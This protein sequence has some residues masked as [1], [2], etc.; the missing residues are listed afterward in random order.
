MT[1]RDRFCRLMTYQSVDRVPAMQV[2]PFEQPAIEQWRKEGLPADQSPQTFLGIESVNF[3]PGAGVCPDP[4]FE[5]KILAEDSES[6]TETTY[7]GAVVRRLNVSPTTF[8]GHVD[9][10]IKTRDDWRAYRERLRPNT[11]RRMRTDL[12]VDAIRAFNESEEPVGLTFFPFFFRLGFYTMGM[13]QF[14]TAF[15]DDP[16]MIHEMFAAAADLVTHALRPILGT[17]RIDF[18]Y[19]VEDIGFKNGPLVSPQT[20]AEFWAPHQGPLLDLLRSHGVPVIAHWSAGNIEKLLPEIIRQGF[21][22]IGPLERMAGMDPIDLRQRHGPQLRLMGGL[23]KEALLAGPAAIDSEIQRLTPLIRQGGF[24][25]M[26]D[27]MVPSECPLAH[28]R[29]LIETLK[30]IRLD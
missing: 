17:I 28:Y 1:P 22:C 23:S 8:Y 5:I 19:F 20:Y 14:L 13:E 18:A 25:P 11:P 24:I 16:D 21:N 9:H 7:M 26:L 4:P 27:D 15:H 10:P 3:V 29:H 2:E 12:T 30:T 6:R